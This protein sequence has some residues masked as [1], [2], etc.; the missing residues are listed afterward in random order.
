MSLDQ[1]AKGMINKQRVADF[2]WIMMMLPELKEL[3]E[4]GVLAKLFDTTAS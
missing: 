1:W 4:K 2:L 3:F